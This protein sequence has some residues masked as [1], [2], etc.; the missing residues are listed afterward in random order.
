MNSVAIVIFGATGDL[1]RR[2]LIPAL[3]KLVADNH[4]HDFVIIGAANSVTSSDELLAR[5]RP[6]IHSVDETVWQKLVERTIYQQLNFT[7]E[8]DYAALRETIERAEMQFNLSGNRLFYLATAA[9]FFCPITQYVACAHLAVRKNADDAVWHRL[10]Y[11]KPFGHDLN[12]AK[13]INECISHSFNE[14]QIY[15]IDHYLTKELVS[16]LALMRFTNALF[17]PLWNNKYIELVQLVLSETVGLEERGVYY[18]QYGAVRDVVQNHILELVALVAMESPKWLTGDY[19]RSQR[20]NVLAHIKVVDGIRG[21]Y[22]GYTQEKGVSPESQVETFAA[23]KLEVANERW[24]GV[25]FYIK[26]GKKLAKKETIIHIKFKQV[27]CLLTKNCPTDSN[28]LTIKIGPDSVFSLELNVKKPG[29]S[30]ALVPICMEFC[31]SCVFGPRTPEAYEILLQEIFKGEQSIAVRTDE[32]EYAWRVADEI[33]ARNFPLYEYKKGS[34]GPEQAEHF[35]RT[36]GM[37]WR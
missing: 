22:E 34:Q 37:Y 10:V 2:K 6:F 5:A 3:Y 25:P 29:V 23:L 7:H 21:Q 8:N 32:I 16:N 35:A 24:S 19:I 20:V 31:H 27:E 33:R 30:D 15:R 13:A 17:E 18:D 9:H 12:S 11:E 28:W 1:T 4:L 36:H 14:V 26:T